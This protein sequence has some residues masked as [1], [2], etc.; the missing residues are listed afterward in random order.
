MIDS[1]KKNSFVMRLDA[2]IQEA[3]CEKG[4]SARVIESDFK[5]KEIVNILMQ[6]ENKAN[7]SKERRNQSKYKYTR[8]KQ[9]T[10]G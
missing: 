1:L 4:D 7:T 3:T 5:A 2:V 9:N 10:N 8:R 6:R